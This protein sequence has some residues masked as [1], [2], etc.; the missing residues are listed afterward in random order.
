[1]AASTG[2]RPSVCSRSSRSRYATAVP[3]RRRR[4]AERMRIGIVR[5]GLIGGS[6]GLA[7]RA[8]ADA[9]V[10]GFDPDPGVR[11]RALALGA[12]AEV[13]EDIAGAVAEAEVVFVAAPVGA[14]AETVAEA[15]AAAPAGCVVSD[16]GST[17]RVVA[18]A[19]ADER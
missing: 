13:S 15:L 12:V 11:E 10:R 17:K 14:L 16:V 2:A 19:C 3:P 6:I 5:V 9:R 7:A 18:D 4:R 1:M 8:R